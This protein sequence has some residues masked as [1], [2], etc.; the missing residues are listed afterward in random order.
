MLYGFLTDDIFIKKQNS[1]LGTFEA[2]NVCFLTERVS[3]YFHQK[4]VVI[5]T[6]TE[7]LTFQNKKI[8]GNMMFF[9][10]KSKY[11]TSIFDDMVSDQI[12]IF[13]NIL[14]RVSLANGEN[15]HD[16]ERDILQDSTL[17]EHYVEDS[18]K[19]ATKS[20]TAT[21]PYI[22]SSTKN[23]EIQMPYYFDI[24]LNFPPSEKEVLRVWL[25]VD[26]FLLDYPLSTITDVILPCDHSYILNPDKA[27]GVIDMLI[28][29]N[30][31]SFKEL[32]DPVKTGDH[33]GFFT[34]NTKY[35][36]KSSHDVN[37]LPFGILYQGA[38]P[39][40]LEIRKAIRD[41][42]LG[43]GTASK[44][45]WET[46]LPDLFVTGQFFLIPLWNNT[47]LRPEKEMYPSICDIKKI[48]QVM[49]VVFPNMEESFIEQYQEI[50]VIGQSEIF[51]TTIPD[52][53][54][55]KEFSIQKIHP[56][57][58]Y[59]MQQDPAFIYQESKTREFNT[60][61][62]RCMAVAQGESTVTDVIRNEFDGL[63]YLSFVASGIEYHMLT[64]ES[65]NELFSS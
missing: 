7:R 26:S 55:E 34:Y 45:V 57:Y 23:V 25:S 4:G 20:V 24:E 65:Y 44:E 42:L 8:T 49:P 50:I 18:L 64:E 38:K 52:P 43:Y 53:L 6:R 17:R 61:L 40:S 47:T 46:I 48:T 56:T 29:S 54:N 30:Q 9:F 5:D 11:E 60:R 28:K 36:V 22:D 21:I 12:K 37:M 59:H 51:I 14:E 58:Q 15:V 13:F 16:I 1:Y 3:N 2:P 31:F 63:I 35:L 41:K 39:T 10:D 32:D 27:T 19:L 33:S 62:N